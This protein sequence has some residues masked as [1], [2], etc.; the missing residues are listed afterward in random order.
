MMDWKIQLFKLNYNELEK[1]AVSDVLDSGWITMGENIIN[2]EKKFGEMLGK[3]VL[4]SA[5]SSGTAAMHLAFLAL[6]IGQNDEVVMPALTFVSDAN[7]ARLVNA[8]PVLADCSSE[9]NW[10]VSAES[11]KKVITDKTKAIVVVHY[12]GYPCD[13]RPIVDLCKE[14]GIYLIE[15]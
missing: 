10:N 15:D 1:K 12:A 13:M 11:I 7:C 8:K 14:E 5:V 3:D 6:D 2:F 9:D 4:C